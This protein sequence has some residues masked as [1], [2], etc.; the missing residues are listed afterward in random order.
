MSLS[1]PGNH[2]TL[3]DWRDNR[4][5]QQVQGRPKLL[6]LARPFPPARRS[7]CTRTWNIAKQLTVL[8]WEV[9]VVTPYPSVWRQADDPAEVEAKL[10]QKG[11]K[12]ILTDHHWRFLAHNRFICWDQGLGRVFA[13]GCRAI[14]RSMGLDNGVGWIAPAEL[15][16]STL[17][18]GDVDVILAT[19]SPPSAFRLAKR[20]SKRLGCPYVMDYRDPWTQNPHREKAPLT[21]R[22][23][24]EARLLSGSAAVTIVSSSWA[25]TLERQHGV[26][27]K[28]HVITNGYDPEDLSNV[29]P[30]E[31]GHFAIVYAGVLYPPKRVITP[32]MQAIK[33]IKEKYDGSAGEYYFHYY[34]SHLEHVREEATRADVTDRVVLHG[35]VSR[36]E[37]LSAVKGASV[38]VV[39]TSVAD[40]A[41]LEERGIVTGKIFDAVGLGATILLIC[42]PDGDAEIV[43]KD[44]ALGQTFR[45][46]QTDQIAAFLWD[47]MSGRRAMQ[48]GN[49]AAYSWPHIAKR[50]D[51]ILRGVLERHPVAIKKTN[52]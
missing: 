44:T 34:G 47:V 1:E 20:L 29:K 42:P 12:R 24:E 33:W 52:N 4:G 17:S 11:I 49:P 22:I 30:V 15:A 36:A 40:Q 26:G 31:F 27:S 39:I 45:G 50:L 18:M 28:L 19:S 10:R 41:S 3:A 7:S 37:A 38:N 48:P 32:V 43:I 46:S 16:C 25:K 14:A 51:G 9:T 8:G 35:Q 23:R 5:A 2:A 13:G 6:F 21:R